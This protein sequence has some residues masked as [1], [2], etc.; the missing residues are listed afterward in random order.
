MSNSFFLQVTPFLVNK[1]NEQRRQILQ[2]AARSRRLTESQ[3]FGQ[4]NELLPSI[5]F[6]TVNCPDRS[7]TLRRA[8]AYIQLKKI[9]YNCKFYLYI[10]LNS[11][12]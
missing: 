10:F 11:C 4:L 1:T 12:D 5:E 6:P 8:I 3:L 7:G 2:E 9:G